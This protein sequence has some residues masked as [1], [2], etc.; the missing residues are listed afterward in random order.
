M[1]FIVVQHPDICGRFSDNLLSRIDHCL[2]IELF[3]HF[4]SFFDSFH[5][6]AAVFSYLHIREKSRSLSYLLVYKSRT[7]NVRLMS[8]PLSALY[9]HLYSLLLL[10]HQT[11]YLTKTSNNVCTPLTK[12]LYLLFVRA[13]NS[14]KWG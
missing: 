3:R 11:N 8:T 1:H 5:I 6:C 2:H 7:G 9:L 14:P 13:E 4:F 12:Y 10:F